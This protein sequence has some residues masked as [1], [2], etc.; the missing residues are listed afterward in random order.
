MR[1]NIISVIDVG[2][3]IKG[4]RLWLTRE[5]GMLKKVKIN[6]AHIKVNTSNGNVDIPGVDNALD[7]TD[8][9]VATT[10]TLDD[11]TNE[12]TLT[13]EDISALGYVPG[14]PW[15][16]ISGE[17]SYG[18]S[19]TPLIP[20]TDS[21]KLVDRYGDGVKY[22]LYVEKYQSYTKKLTFTVPG[23]FEDDTLNI[24]WYNTQEEPP[25]TFS[26]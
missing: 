14:L 18:T 10:V 26:Y 2:I 6:N 19:M 13:D 11:V 22:D 5:N 15:L 17:F 1:C 7:T 8:M 4:V 16:I 23:T 9:V 3:I 12:I 25:L 20:G 21:M 24:D